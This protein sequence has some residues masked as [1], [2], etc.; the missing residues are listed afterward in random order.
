VI[1]RH[2]LSA[3]RSTDLESALK[4]RPG[5]SGRPEIP[6]SPKITV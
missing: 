2:P 4:T 3:K 5:I 1:W 6:E